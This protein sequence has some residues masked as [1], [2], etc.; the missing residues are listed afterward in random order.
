MASY[1]DNKI[2]KVEFMTDLRTGR[3]RISV[4][5][6]KDP[7]EEGVETFESVFGPGTSDFE[8]ESDIPRS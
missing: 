7:F 5:Q 8:E 1:Y 4:L 3:K 6:E 2:E